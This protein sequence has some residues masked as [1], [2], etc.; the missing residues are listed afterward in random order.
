M[1][2]L[3]AY[4][5]P[6]GLAHFFRLRGQINF[7]YA[8]MKKYLKNFEKPLVFAGGYCIIIYMDNDLGVTEMEKM[9][10]GLWLDVA[11]GFAQADDGFGNL[12]P[13]HYKKLIHSACDAN[14]IF[15]L[16]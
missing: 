16:Y 9:A 4:A 13:V 7:A 11:T 3:V 10:F 5:R 12:V 14:L 1:Q 6:G 15:D 2:N 8:G